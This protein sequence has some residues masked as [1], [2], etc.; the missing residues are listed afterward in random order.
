MFESTG[1]KGISVGER[2][3][4]AVDG[5]VFVRCHIGLE[6]KDRSYVNYGENLIED[7]GIAINL[8]KKNWRYEGGG[9]FKGD[10]IFAINCEQN[11]KMDKHSTANFQS[12]ETS[13]P[14]LPVWQKTIEEAGSFAPM[15][16]KD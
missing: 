3:N 8:Y 7:S 9:R 12:I 10:I 14:G 13:D 16:N 15:S 4:L 6:V 2:T 1:D 11:L 5:C